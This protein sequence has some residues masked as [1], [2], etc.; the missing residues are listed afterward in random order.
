MWL[1]GMLELLTCMMYGMF[2][3]TDWSARVWQKI[4]G[5]GLTLWV[6]FRRRIKVNTNTSHK[7]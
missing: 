6:Q 2:A 5:Y 3:S 7:Y 4:V 1:L